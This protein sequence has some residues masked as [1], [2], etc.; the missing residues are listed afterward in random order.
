[1]QP[2][3][4][5]LQSR[6]LIQVGLTL[7]LCALLVGLAVPAFGVPRLGLSAHLLGLLQGIFLMLIGVLRPKLRLGRGGWATA[8]L[9]IYGC[10]SAWL[11]T[12]LAGIWRAGGALLPMAAGSAHG[13]FV[14]EIVITLALR[15]SAVTL[16]GALLL[17]LWGTRG[18]VAGES[19]A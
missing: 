14:Q 7:F 2:A 17:L 13:T 16:L 18:L 6:L 5:S 10:L 11:A 3:A 19:T 9:L 15:S 12:V 4:P 1:M 8:G